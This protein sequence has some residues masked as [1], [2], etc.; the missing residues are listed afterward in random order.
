MTAT[1]G[2]EGLSSSGVKT[3]PPNGFDAEGEK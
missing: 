1:G 2:A 3:R